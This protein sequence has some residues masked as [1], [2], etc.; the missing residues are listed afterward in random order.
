MLTDIH[1]DEIVAFGWP[2]HG[3]VRSVLNDHVLELPGGG[4]MELERFAPADG[5]VT[6]LY[7]AGLP[8]IEDAAVEAAD[9]AWWGRAILRDGR[10]WSGMRANPGSGSLESNER[11]VPLCWPDH[12]GPPQMI[13]YSSLTDGTPQIFWGSWPAVNSVDISGRWTNSELG[14]GT[15][16]PESAAKLV[17]GSSWSWRLS[18]QQPGYQVRY[19]FLGAHQNRLLFGLYL[20]PS[21]FD[22]ELPAPPGT[23]AGSS[24]DGAPQALCG[25]IEV[26]I[27]R[28]LF[29]P[30][31]DPDEH[32]T[33]HVLEDRS[34]ALGNPFHD[35]VDVE[36]GGGSTR[37]RVE[38]A[39]ET[40]ALLT[41]WYDASGVVRTA[42]FNR[43]QHA[44]YEHLYV[45]GDRYWVTSRRTVFTLLYGGT[46][47]DERELGEELEITSVDGSTT[48]TRRVFTTGAE[49]DITTWTGPYA[50]SLTLAPSPPT[51]S[52][53]G[54]NLV[55]GAVT[56]IVNIP[57]FGSVLRDQDIQ[58][59]WLVAHSNNVASICSSR[60]PY[61][62]PPGSN[63][64]IV[65]A[66]SGP[67]IG[68]AG[69]RG[70]ALTSLVPKGRGPTNPYLR[71]FFALPRWV[72]GTGNPVTGQIVRASDYY[73]IPNVIYSWV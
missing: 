24:I 55:M 40:S 33:L 67:A 57:G 61:D 71:S 19:R 38:E 37:H 53:A 65:E 31:G 25:L 9:G 23:A 32:L 28:E 2:W 39:S 68:P 50:G 56:Y 3:L 16:Q 47:V 44:E 20:L 30:E 14:Q 45:S 29:G 54:A 70:G 17:S 34:V 11:V 5:N 1:D 43:E 46:V 60:E 51:V 52:R 7:D 59:I 15:D 36:G 73:D 12:D 49:T 48:I 62:Y 10:F 63:S 8:D 41:A 72:T 58:L 22:S 6:W 21:V 66:R 4:E 64:Y 18:G 69:P 35:V 26:E 42:R 13:I 27:A